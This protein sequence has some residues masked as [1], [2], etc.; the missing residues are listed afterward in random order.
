MWKATLTML[1]LSSFYYW[2]GF[3]YPP[4]QQT[5]ATTQYSFHYFSFS[6]FP[7][8]PLCLFYFLH[9]HSTGKWILDPLLLS[10]FNGDLQICFFYAAPFSCLPQMLSMWQSKHIALLS[11]IPFL[12]SMWLFVTDST[13]PLLSQCSFGKL[14]PSHPF[15]K[16]R[17]GLAH[18]A[19]S[20]CSRNA[21]NWN[22]IKFWALLYIV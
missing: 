20:T 3:Y 21:A 6:H 12:K 9:C 7:F 16:K 18:Q 11:P 2:T 4:T 13:A 15:Y 22:H 19:L 8:T 5:D 10:A 17:L 1:G 14:H